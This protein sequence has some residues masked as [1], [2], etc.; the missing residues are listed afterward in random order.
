MKCECLTLKGTPC[1]NSARPG[2]KTC[3]AHKNGC[4]S[5]KTAK[6]KTEVRVKSSPSPKPKSP[7][8]KP[9]PSPHSKRNAPYSPS[10]NRVREK[11]RREIEERHQS[12]LRSSRI[13]AENEIIRK[14]E[15]TQRLR[16]EEKI[17]RDE[18]LRKEYEKSD[19]YKQAQA[20][21]KAN[22]K[23]NYD[24]GNDGE[25]AFEYA[26]HLKEEMSQNICYSDNG[27]YLGK[28]IRTSHDG[29][30]TSSGVTYRM[31]FEHGILS[32]DAGYGAAQYLYFRPIQ[33]TACQ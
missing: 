3:A 11:S 32:A 22:R 18:L 4:S 6:A 5:T 28:F 33:R 19:A 7:S 10:P 9:K 13:N 23:K 20:L 14:Q 15:E 1:K 17:K 2:F 31:H 8:P 26:R 25:S 21:E 16:D 24:F 27:K 29:D 12:Y 30:H